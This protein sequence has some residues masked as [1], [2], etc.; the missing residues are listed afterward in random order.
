MKVTFALAVLLHAVN[1]FLDWPFL[2][3]SAP[4]MQL[5]AGVT[6]VSAT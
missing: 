4:P 3:I 2:C 6:D 5:V 1:G